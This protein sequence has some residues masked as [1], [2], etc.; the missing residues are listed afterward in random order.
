[1]E[2]MRADYLG[3]LGKVPEHLGWT[4]APASRSLLCFSR[5]S[6]IPSLFRHLLQRYLKYRYLGGTLGKVPNTIDFSYLKKYEWQ[7]ATIAPVGGGV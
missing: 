4:P 5:L 6:N 3:T 2:A 7:Q 1:M